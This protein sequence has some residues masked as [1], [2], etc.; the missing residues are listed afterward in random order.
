MRR[1][2]ARRLVGNCSR[3]LASRCVASRVASGKL[4]DRLFYRFGRCVL[5]LAEGLVLHASYLL[6]GLLG[7]LANTGF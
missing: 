7:L 4:E 3:M 2:L 1:L 6:G 5:H